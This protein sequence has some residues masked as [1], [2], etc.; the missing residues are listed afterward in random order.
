MHK[1]SPLRWRTPDEIPCPICLPCPA[2]ITGKRLLPPA[3]IARIDKPEEAD[4]D[5]FSLEL[6][7]IVK[8]AMAALEAAHHRRDIDRGT[9]T[10]RPV[11]PP[12]PRVAIEQAD[13]H[14]AHA[15]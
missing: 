7:A 13:R 11:D 3:C 2:V 12:L 5:R 15:A 14:P 6:F 1:R 4:G 9:V 10:V 8:L